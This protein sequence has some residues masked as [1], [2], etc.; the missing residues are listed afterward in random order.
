MLAAALKHG[1]V[2]ETLYFDPRPRCPPL[3]AEVEQVAG[4][5][6]G[7]GERGQPRQRVA[8]DRRLARAVGGAGRAVALPARRRRSRQRRHDP[9]RGGG[10]RRRD[11]SPSARGPPTRSAR[12][13]CG[14]A[15]ARS[16]ASPW[17]A[18]PGTRRARRAIWRWRWCPASGTPLRELAA[19]GAAAVRA[20]SRAHG[21]AARDRGRLRRGRPRPGRR[22]RLAQ[23]RDDGDALPL[24]I[25]C[26]LRCL[27]RRSTPSRRWSDSAAW[28]RRAS[29]PC[30]RPAP[31]TQ[32]E[33]LRVRYLGRKA[34]L[35]QILRSIPCL[36]EEWR[37]QLGKR[38][39]EARRALEALLEERSTRARRGR[40][41]RTGCASEAIDVTLPGEP[42]DAGHLHLLTTTRRE[43]ED[44]FV[45]LG[46]PRGRGAR[47]RARLL[48]LHRAQ[49]SARAPG[50]DAAGH[51]LLLGRG[52]AAHAHLAHAGARDGAAGAAHLHRRARAR[53]TGATPTRPTRRCSISSRGSRW[54]RASRSPT[55]RARCIRSRASSSAATGACACARTTSRSPSRASSSTSRASR[56]AAP[57]GC[58]TARATRCA[59]ARAGSRA[60]AP[61][62]S[63]PTCS[64]S[65]EKHGY[66]PEHVQGFAFGLG[67]D[68]MAM[69]KHGVPDLRLLFENDLRF[70]EQF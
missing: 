45:G 58:A 43:L 56:A 50:A 2:P 31:R 52:A 1:R 69:L 49:P 41:S 38:G 7:A 64:G 48:Q 53:S 65:C 21:P 26:T 39:N 15:W 60:G 27:T 18:R 20:G 16:S 28:R 36:P 34:E 55:C 67:I 42:L 24:R 9:A 4:R 70:L 37:A 44:I 47:G 32:L 46:L 8:G 51:L 54:T 35:T 14:P 63:T 19:A 40:S 23:R 62:W 33:E 30:S 17:C 13:R 11:R 57:A 68:R 66:D 25:S 12:R 29:A 10:V 59:R 61:A 22:R 5:P 3:P 6:R